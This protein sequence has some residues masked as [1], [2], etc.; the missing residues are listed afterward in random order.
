MV[1][2]QAC[3]RDP[4]TTRNYSTPSIDARWAETHETH[5]AV[6]TAI[7]A[8]S[9]ANR[10][11]QAI[12]EEPTDAEWGHVTMAVQEYVANGDFPAEDDGRYHWG[13]EVITL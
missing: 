7:H 5:V 10:S 12:W 1:P 3:G 4:M 6:A 8:I 13:Q 11:P 9:D 2:V